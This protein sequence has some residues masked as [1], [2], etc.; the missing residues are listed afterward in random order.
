MAAT[1][2]QTVAAILVAAGDGSRL[3]ANIPK[4]FVNVAGRT[5]LEHAL[6]RFVDHPRV[7]EVVVVA[8][9]AMLDAAAALVPSARVV[10][11]AATRQ[12]SV[13]CG[14]AVVSDAADCVL[15]HDVARPFV[16][17]EVIDAVL[18]ALAGGAVA[19]V[20]TLAVTDTIRR[21][22]AATGELGAL[23]DRSALR[24]M[25]TPQG[26]VR[27]VLVAAHAGSVAAGSLHSGATDDAAL[28]EAIGEH[29]VSVPGD[30]RSFK[31]T[32]PLDLALAEVVALR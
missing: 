23:V 29:V 12:E 17:A 24:A 32:H 21:F 16:T 10:A 1:G 8:P 31:I 5:I 19:V 6:D 2:R 13:S 9:A 7:G 4:A 22:D 30:V 20:P 28:V 15:V 18:D 27:S 3:G 11:G 26:F 25:Q 14:L